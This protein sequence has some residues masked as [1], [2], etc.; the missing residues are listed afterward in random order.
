MVLE[1]KL[2]ISSRYADLAKLI[3]RDFWVLGPVLRAKTLK[4]DNPKFFEN[5]NWV[6]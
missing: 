1:A 4:L 2:Q 6:F 3:F 5:A